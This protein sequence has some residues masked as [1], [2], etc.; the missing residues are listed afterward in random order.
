[1]KKIAAVL[2]SISI[3]TSCVTNNYRSSNGTKD[4]SLVKSGAKYNIYDQK[5]QKHT[6]IIQSIEQDSIKGLKGAQNFVI[7]KEDVRKITQF[8][9]TKTIML[10]G[11]VALFVASGIV[12]I[13]AMLKGSEALGNIIMGK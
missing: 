5:F 8:N 12:I 11:G 2:L 4:F 1:M 7:A 9:P 6:I 3:L 13:K 10:A